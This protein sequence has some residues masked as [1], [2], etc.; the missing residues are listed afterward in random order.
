MCDEID[1]NRVME[2]LPLEAKK[3]VIGM[4]PLPIDWV[5]GFKEGDTE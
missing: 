1:S 5:R 3:A 2:Y 4:P